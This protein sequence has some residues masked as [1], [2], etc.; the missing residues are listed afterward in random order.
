MSENPLYQSRGINITP[1]ELTKY[2]EEFCTACAMGESMSTPKLGPDRQQTKPKIGERFHVDFTGPNPTESIHRY[3]YSIIIADEATGYI[4]QYCSKC[5]DDA[6]TLA[7]LKQIDTSV[8][9]NQHIKPNRTYMMSDNG[10]FA[11]AKVTYACRKAGTMQLFTP[12]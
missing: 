7:I 5:K 3:L 2:K 11:S 8:V 12:P 6:S 10:E 1:F 4:W 9:E